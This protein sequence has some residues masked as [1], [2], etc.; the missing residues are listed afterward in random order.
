MHPHIS[1]LVNMLIYILIVRLTILAF[2]I[3]TV[4]VC[5]IDGSKL[6]A[7]NGDRQALFCEVPHPELYDEGDRF[8]KLN[9]T[10]P[11]NSHRRLTKHKADSHG[12]E[13]LSAFLLT[14]T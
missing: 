8:S 1:R 9:P 4:P 5:S 13:V 3:A 11:L 7:Y 10:C 2:S 6:M 12:V 14:C